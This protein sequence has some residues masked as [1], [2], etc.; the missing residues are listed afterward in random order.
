M[1]FTFSLISQADGLY[2][3]ILGFPHTFW[4]DQEH[5]MFQAPEILF[6]RIFEGAL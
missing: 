5:G 1:I 6:L 2:Y 4:Q 3:F